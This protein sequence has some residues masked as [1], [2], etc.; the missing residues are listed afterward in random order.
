MPEESC[1]KTSQAEYGVKRKGD[2]SGAGLLGSL[3]QPAA[4][5]G[6]HL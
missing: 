6:V 2:S 4:A 3:V 1:G 5:Q